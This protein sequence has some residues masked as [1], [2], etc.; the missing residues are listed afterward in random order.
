MPYS[1]QRRVL[2]VVC[3]V[4][5]LVLWMVPGNVVELIARGRH[6]LL[7]RYSREQFTWI[8]VAGIASLIAFYIG[9]P[10]ASGRRRRAFRVLVGL[11]VGL[12]LVFGMDVAMTLVRAS[13]SA[14]YVIDGL[15]YHR[16]AGYQVSEVYEDRPEAE[17]SYPDRPGG[18]GQVAYDFSFDGRGFRNAEALERCEVLVLGDSFAEG[19]RVSGGDAWPARLAVA[20]G[21]SVYNLGMSGYDPQHYLAAL[22]KHGLAL[23]PKLVVCLLYEGNDFRSAK[24][25]ENPEE[26]RPPFGKVFQQYLRNSLVIGSVDRVLTETLG[27]M[28]SDGPVSGGEAISWLPV[29]IGR[30]TKRSHYAFAPKRMMRHYETAEE[31]VEGEDWEVSRRILREIKKACEEGGAELLMVYAPD[32]PHVVLSVA[33]GELPAEQVRAFG[34]LKKKKLP[35]AD[36]FVKELVAGLEVKE[37]VTRAFCE[38]ESIAFVSAT[39]VLSEAAGSGRQVYYTYD[40]HWTPI[41]HEVV[42]GLLADSLGGQF[43]GLF[44]SSVEDTFRKASVPLDPME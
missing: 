24:W 29:G 25:I 17:R 15:A 37:G 26:Y 39:G 40:Q 19:S 32:K 16:P 20:T 6:V 41:G 12:P 34:A 7:G 5:N 31:F 10:N 2:V 21:L 13:A 1:I 30:G 28:R 38:S 27:G 4:L 3:V 22:K 33:A 11:G 9:L 42:A 8:L 43:A 14:P 44:D 23:G 35:E 18:F 36:V